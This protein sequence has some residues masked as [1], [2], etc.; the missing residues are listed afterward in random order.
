[1]K[2]QSLSSGI[3]V[4]VLG[5]SMPYQSPLLITENLPSVVMYADSKTKCE[6]GRVYQAED[7][8]WYLS[9]AYLNNWSATEVFAKYKG[10]L[11]LNALHANRDA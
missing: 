1:M 4:V 6:V 8:R 10:F 5:E 9:S 3:T 11:F 2:L 7:G